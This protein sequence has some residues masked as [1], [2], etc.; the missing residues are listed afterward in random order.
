MNS[1]ACNPVQLPSREDILLAIRLYIRH[2]YEGDPPPK[3]ARLLPPE[4]F[5]PA[6]WLM[7]DAPERDPP[8]APLH[9]V[10]S[11]ALRLGNTGYPNMKLR[12]SRPPRDRAFLF[13]VDSHDAFLSASSGSPDREALDRIK[14]RN[15]EISAA[16][17]AGWDDAGL[18][19][20]RSYLRNKI[21]QAK[22]KKKNP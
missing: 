21:E 5:R 6:E 12:L 18:A 8:A 17:T 2:A 1:A 22:D 14:R 20:E 3:A 16:I 4:G 10:R 7:S 9:N 19:T 13:S 11:F 15:A